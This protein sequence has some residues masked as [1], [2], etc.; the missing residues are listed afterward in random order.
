M[1]ASFWHNKWEIGQ[2]GFHENETNPFL[3][4]HLDKLQLRSD[5]NNGVRIFVP[6]CGKTL[7]I[8]YLL[9]LGYKVVGVEFSE[10]AIKELFQE[11]GVTPTISK[12]QNFTHYQA[13]NID[14]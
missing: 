5:L 12:N 4:K 9:S 14:V 6:L 8:H 1:E 7:D 3:V 13:Q 2:I 10:L 11:L